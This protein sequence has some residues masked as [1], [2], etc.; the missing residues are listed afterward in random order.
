MTQGSRWAQYRP[1]PSTADEPDIGSAYTEIVCSGSG[2]LAVRYAPEYTADWD[3]YPWTTDLDSPPWGP[4]SS[5]H[6]VSGAARIVIP[7]DFRSYFE[8]EDPLDQ[9]LMLV[10]CT[11][12]AVSVDQV[13]NVETRKDGTVWETDIEAGRWSEW[14]EGIEAF[15][16][17]GFPGGSA[18]GEAATVWKTDAAGP[19]HDLGYPGVW[20]AFTYADYAADAQPMLD[21]VPGTP[22]GGRVDYA[23]GAQDAPTGGTYKVSRGWSFWMPQGARLT[24]QRDVQ[25]MP[26]APNRPQTWQVLDK[27]DGFGAMHRATYRSVPEVI[28]R[29]MK[30]F[31]QPA[32]WFGTT[33]NGTEWVYYPGGRQ[34]INWAY[35]DGARV[36]YDGDEWEWLGWQFRDTETD[37]RDDSWGYHSVGPN[38]A[39]RLAWHTGRLYHDESYNWPAFNATF[40]PTVVVTY[41]I[42]EWDIGDPWPEPGTGAYSYTHDTGAPY[43]ASDDGTTVL[44]RHPMEGTKEMAV[45]SRSILEHGRGDKPHTLLVEAR[46]DAGMDWEDDV[47]LV[48]VARTPRWRTWQPAL[49]RVDLPSAQEGTPRPAPLSVGL[50]SPKGEQWRKVGDESWRDGP[51]RLKMAVPT[52]Q[53]PSGWLMEVKPG[54]DTS[55]ARWVTVD[56]PGGRPRAVRMVPWPGRNAV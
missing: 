19:L 35:K 24:T 20:P 36:H 30:A 56:V 55:R 42:F 31:P 47:N 54:D 1:W 17:V 37:N 40:P 25:L 29:A 8:Q 48:A 14:H 22:Y 45:M 33:W 16:P 27:V 5:E 43:S 28:T 38:G 6:Q 53:S 13:R 41:D 46:Q 2:T 10:E 51:G 23:N 7:A 50:E 15:I 3:W 39:M 12:G 34:N 11:S 52:S 49:R 32:R 21:A 44:I 4:V 26:F 9:V 18:P